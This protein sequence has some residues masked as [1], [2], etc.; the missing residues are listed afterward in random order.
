MTTST[1]IHTDVHQ[2][3]QIDRRVD[4][5]K[6]GTASEDRASAYVIVLGTKSQRRR[7]QDDLDGEP[8]GVP[9]RAGAQRPGRRL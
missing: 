4:G 9:C 2:D 5:R 8:R 6:D 7:H 3:R 1:P